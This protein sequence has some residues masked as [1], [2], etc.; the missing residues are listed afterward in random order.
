MKRFS[1]VQ[2]F[3]AVVILALLLCFSGCKKEEPKGKPVKIGAILPLTGDASYYGESIKKAIDLLVVQING[4]GGINGKNIV[5]VYEDSK[6]KPADGVAGFRKLIDIDGVQAVIGDAVSS[7][8]LAL[9]PIANKEKVVVLS[10]LSSSP[11]ITNAGDFVFRNVPSDQLGGRVAGVFVARIQRWKKAAI[12]FIN[13]DFGYGLTEAFAQEVERNNGQITAKE[14]YEQGATDFRSQLSKIKIKEPDCIFV[15]GYREVPQILVQSKELGVKAKFIGTGLLEDPKTIEIAG[16]AAEGVFLTQLQ[17]TDDSNDPTTQHFVTDFSKRY[18]SP[19]NIISA[20]GYDSMKL[21]ST[22]IAEGNLTGE[23]IKNGLYKIHDF[24]GVTGIIS[25]DIN[26]DVYQPMGVKIIHEG[27]FVWF[28][29]N[30]SV[31]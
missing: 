12:L 7:V 22:V 18:S 20:Y 23:D 16:D 24:R 19:P 8:T 15:V 25:F 28:A 30:I 1:L 9:A 27:K 31:E 6:A 5:I 13:N 2:P 26:G 10:P 14:S 17:Y 3:L 4:S 29:R 11:E 21:L